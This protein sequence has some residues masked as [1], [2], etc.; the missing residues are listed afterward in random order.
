MDN[1]SPVEVLPTVYYYSFSTGQVN[2]MQKVKSPPLRSQN[3]EAVLYALN[4]IAILANELQEEPSSYFE[5]ERL[6]ELGNKLARAWLGKINFDRS[7]FRKMMG[8]YD[9]IRRTWPL[10]VQDACMRL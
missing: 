10:V 7:T 2:A 9:A 3:A 6:D 8:P 5:G 1:R 4:E